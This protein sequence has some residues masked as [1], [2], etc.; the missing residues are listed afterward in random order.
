MDDSLTRSK[1]ADKILSALSPTSAVSVLDDRLEYARLAGD[2]IADWLEQRYKIEQRYATDLA[3]LSARVMGPDVSTIGLGSFTGVWNKFVE[4]TA[5]LAGASH[6]FANKISSEMMSPIRQHGERSPALVE[7]PAIQQNLARVAQDIDE[8]EEK[9]EKYKRK[10]SKKVAGANQYV[11]NTVA[12]WDSQ[13]PLV[14]EKLQ[15]IDHARFLM[16]KDVLTRFSTSEVDKAQRIVSLC[17]ANLNEFLS[18]E[19]EDEIEMF[20]V[21]IQTNGAPT[22]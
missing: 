5:T 18:F 17:E 12:E 14:F 16:L 19:P 21:G 20:A 15:A 1:Y 10:G 22:P 7:M 3:A 13:A 2:Q 9:A 8:A 6:S 11:N 4:S